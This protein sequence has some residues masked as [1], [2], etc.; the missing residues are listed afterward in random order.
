[1]KKKPHRHNIDVIPPEDFGE[2]CVGVGGCIGGA[3]MVNS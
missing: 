1:M 3:A 2:V